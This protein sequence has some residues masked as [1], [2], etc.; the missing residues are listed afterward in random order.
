MTSLQLITIAT[1]SGLIAFLW[2]FFFAPQN[3]P[4][5]PITESPTSR[6]PHPSPLIP[7]PP[8]ATCN[9]SIG[10][11]TCAACVNRIEKAIRKVPGVVY[12]QVNLLSN[13]GTASFDP[14]QTKPSDIA[15][16]VENI[17]Y[18]ASVVVPG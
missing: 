2:W 5:H 14:T 10:G 12:T 17:G 6:N 4:N 9:L 15:A 11:M 7:R 1:G 18:D 8:V 13:S 16:A 3:P